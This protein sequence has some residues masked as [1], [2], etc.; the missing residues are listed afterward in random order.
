MVEEHKRHRRP[1][2]VTKKYYLSPDVVALIEAEG[3]RTGYPRNIVIEIMVRERFGK[4]PEEA[5]ASVVPKPVR[6]PRAP[7]IPKVKVDLGL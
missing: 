1:G 4:P 3:E 5:L 7:A 6:A 2:K